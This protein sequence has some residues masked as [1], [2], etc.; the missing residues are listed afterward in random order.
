MS[1]TELAQ[2]IAVI[3]AKVEAALSNAEQKFADM[4]SPLAKHV[5]ADIGLDA[6]QDS[7]VGVAAAVAAAAC[8]PPAMADAALAAVRASVAIQA[9]KELSY[10]TEQAAALNAVAQAQ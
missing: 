2:D 6:L 1:L 7:E 3:L 9:G 10:V 5:M 4:F 8:G